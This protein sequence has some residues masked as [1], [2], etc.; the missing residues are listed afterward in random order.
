VEY[1]PFAEELRLCGCDAPLPS[2]MRCPSSSGIDLPA[3]P[4]FNKLGVWE[5]RKS[6]ILLAVL[7]LGVRL[8]RED[9]LEIMLVASDFRFP[10]FTD[11]MDMA[12][13]GR[14]FEALGGC[15]KAPMLTVFL[16]PF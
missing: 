13:F 5:L 4:P 16:T 10:E 12:V 9:P 15:G 3:P 7:T 14:E 8:L 1:E 11:A 2:D 6:L